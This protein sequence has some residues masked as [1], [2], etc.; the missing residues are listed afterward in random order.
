[1]QIKIITIISTISLLFFACIKQVNPDL[2]NEKPI[3]V[4]E[5]SITTDSVLYTVRLTYSG[6]YKYGLDIPEGFLEKNAAVYIRDDLGNQTRLVYKDKGI[7]ETTD[8]AYVGKPGRSYSVIIELQNGKKYISEPE[9]I[10]PSVPIES[11]KVNFVPDFNLVHPAYLQV[12]VNAKDPA[13]EE[14]YYRWTF[15]SWILRQTKGVPCGN[16]CIFAEYCFQ[17]IT[18]KEVRILSDASINGNQIINQPAG[19]S[20]IY[21]YGNHYVDIGQHSLTREAYQFWRKYDD[22]VSRTGNTLDPLPASVKG[23]VHNA[24]DPADIALGYFSASSV[25]HKRAILIPY[26]ITPYF[27]NISAVSFI[28]PE[29]VACFDKFPDTQSYAMPPADQ[30]PPPPGWQNADTVK[31]FW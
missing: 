21:T 30:Y 27:L 6:P 7:Y 2:R 17:R 25:T 19:K 10:K 20:Y 9:E 26:S 11:Y 13:S 31:V 5:G 29:N 28:P 8:P 12:S 15:Y 1:M 22:Q 16:L 24:S 14:N 3:L 23:N 4:V 18:D